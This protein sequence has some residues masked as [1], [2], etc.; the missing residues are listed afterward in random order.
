VT[1]IAAGLFLVFAWWI[2]KSV[3]LNMVDNETG[4]VYPLLGPW[5]AVIAGTVSGV[6]SAS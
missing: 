1:F 4:R 2:T 6:R 5:F 3:P